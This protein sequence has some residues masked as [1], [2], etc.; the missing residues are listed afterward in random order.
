V[1][2]PA[3]SCGNAIRSASASAHF[4]V[5]VAGIFTHSPVGSPP[6][7]VW[8]YSAYRA[9]AENRIP[10]RI[11]VT[12]AAAGGASASHTSRHWPDLSHHRVSS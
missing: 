8:T 12:F 4:A 6:F 9:T 10:L 7:F 5:M 2:T 3:K 11:T 1:Y